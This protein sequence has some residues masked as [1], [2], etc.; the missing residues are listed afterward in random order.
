MPCGSFS[1]PIKDLAVSAFQAVLKILAVVITIVAGLH[2]A[3]G[4]NSEILLGARWP[5]GAALDA[6]IDSQ[7]R[8]YG[9]AFLV[10]A[11]LLWL[12]GSDLKRYEPVLKTMF[13]VFFFAGLARFV[14]FALVGAPSAMII[15]L[16]AFEIASPLVL[17]LWLTRLLRQPHT[18]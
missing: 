5:Q 3:M 12:C 17:W 11:C 18:A 6:T 16:W 14:S 13:A 4:T 2:V 9:A 8:F 1:S 7:D 10:Y 15:F